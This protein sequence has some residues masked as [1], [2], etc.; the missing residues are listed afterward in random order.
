MIDKR[1]PSTFASALALSAVLAGCGGSPSYNAGS[2]ESAQIDMGPADYDAGGTM[3]CSAGR[4]SF[5]EACGWR[6][7]RDGS[8]GAEIWISNIARETK[9]AYRVLTFSKGE[10]TTRDGTPLQAT[11][12]G[13]R[14]TITASD[15]GF[16]RFPDAVITGG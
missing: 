1:A 3:P 8:G 16:F 9:P 7:V 10:F 11:R 6:V 12:D 2:T 5:N 4:A 15:G 14:W 13:D